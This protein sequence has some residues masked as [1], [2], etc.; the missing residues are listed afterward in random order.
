[1]AAVKLRRRQV[2]QT[3]LVLINQ[4]AALFGRGP[5]LAGDFQ[6]R[7]EPRRLPLDHGERI[8]RLRGDDGRRLPL[9][10]AGFFRRDLL[11]RVAEKI[12]VID[13]NA[14]DDGGERMIDH[15][16][17]VQPAAEADFEQQHVGRMTREQHHADRRGDLEHGDG[18]AA[19]DA[20]AFLQRRAKFLVA[21]QARRP[22]R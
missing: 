12:G 11:D 18:L 10:N 1:M 20:L 4:P 6:R 16:G 22:S 13:R 3:R 19:I 15:I 7:I 9:E 5:I 8:A 14:R 21:H 17:R 2:E